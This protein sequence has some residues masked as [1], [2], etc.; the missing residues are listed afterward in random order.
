[1]ISIQ[2]YYEDNKKRKVFPL[3]KFTIFL[4]NHWNLWLIWNRNNVLIFVI[5]V[6]EISLMMMANIGSLIMDYQLKNNYLK[7]FQR[8]IFHNFK[9]MFI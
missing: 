9:V 3:W 2:K 5:F 6:Q 7:V 4:F 8:T 1:M